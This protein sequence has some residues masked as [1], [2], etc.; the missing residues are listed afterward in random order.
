M[1]KEG[2]GIRRAA[3]ET[4]RLKLARVR[5]ES[6]QAVSGGLALL[7]QT[8]ADA[9][10]VDRVGVWF[11]EDQ[12]RTLVCREQFIRSGRRHISGTVLR[13]RDFPNYM[14]A[15]RERRA[16]VADDA[17]R[18]P[19]TGELADAYLGPNQIASLLDAPIIRQG[20]V[21][22][23]VCHEREDTPRP[24]SEREVDFAGSVGD[25][26]ALL[27]EQGERV[28]LEAALK[29]QTEQRLERQKLDA[30]ALLARSVA[31]DLNNVLS[32]LLV[33]ASEV[34]EKGLTEI[35]QSMSA[36]VDAGRHL[37]NQL[38]DLGARTVK[39][40]GATDVGKLVQQLAGSLRALATPAVRLHVDV[41]DSDA[42]AL[43]GEGALE[44]ILFNLVANARDAVGESGGDVEVVVRRAEPE[45]EVPPDFVVLEVVDNGCGMDARTRLHLFEP[46]FTTK[47]QGHGLGLATVYGLITRAG[48]SIDVASQL[49]H[50]ST[51]R[52]ALQ[53]A[54]GAQR[55]S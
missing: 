3:F 44:R 5:L 48:G 21:I 19:I 22:G 18:H 37:S 34:E 53:R 17:V 24:W 46:Y 35:A 7:T 42:Q 36:A 10:D 29:I 8:V 49:G 41:R 2:G 31:H 27:L 40:P 20:R 55:K 1:S 16:I 15:L 47:S 12:D 26:V 50:G 13:S 54:T 43:I 11:L 52:I 33:A 9:M 32:V 45:D 23:V 6:G 38:S 51:F 30:L 4:A 14:R 39:Q 28:E 25:L